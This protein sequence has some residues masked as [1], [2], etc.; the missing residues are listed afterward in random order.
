MLLDNISKRGLV[1]ILGGMLYALIEISAR[2]YTH[3]SMVLT[4]GLCLTLM[5]EIEHR[6][7]LNFWVKCLCGA[8]I[9]TTFE[10]IVGVVV[11]LIMH[12]NVWDYSYLPLNVLGQICV[13]YFFIWYL[14]SILGFIICSFVEKRLA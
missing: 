2:G 1:F 8:I 14:V 5:Y 3:W 4:G 6:T 12:W 10:F 13:P 7:R 11:N 9:I